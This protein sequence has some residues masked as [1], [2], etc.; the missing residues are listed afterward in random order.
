VLSFPPSVHLLVL[1]KVKVTRAIKKVRPRAERLYFMRASSAKKES[2]LRV[3]T[4]AMILWNSFVVPFH[5]LTGVHGVVGDISNTI[6]HRLLHT[7]AK[8]DAG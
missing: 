4:H 3:E 7:G 5:F 8:N 6:S 2:R 1:K